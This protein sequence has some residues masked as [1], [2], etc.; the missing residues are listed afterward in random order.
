MTGG[1]AK[2]VFTNISAG[3]KHEKVVKRDPKIINSLLRDTLCSE[4]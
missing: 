1:L 3:T 4:R 2:P